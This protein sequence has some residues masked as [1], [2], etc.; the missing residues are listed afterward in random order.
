MVFNAGINLTADT[1]KRDITGKIVAGVFPNKIRDTEIM[2]TLKRA[3][4]S[5]NNLGVCETRLAKNAISSLFLTIF[6]K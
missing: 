3:T 1:A 2:A 4:T 6:L 5:K